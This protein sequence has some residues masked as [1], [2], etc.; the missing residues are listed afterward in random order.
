MQ[1]QPWLGRFHILQILFNRLNSQTALFR[2]TVN[3]QETE[4]EESPSTYGPV[5]RE[6]KSLDLKGGPP[7]AI[8][9]P[10]ICIT[11]SRGELSS[12]DAEGC[13]K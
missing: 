10:P 11:V 13:I 8:L 3:R 7:D 12:G 1:H 2:R 4:I 5:V 6:Q 9:P